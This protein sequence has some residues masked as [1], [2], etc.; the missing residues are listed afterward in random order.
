[1]SLLRTGTRPRG[2]SSEALEVIVVLKV[3]VQVVALSGITLFS[4]ML[5]FSI[6]RLDGTM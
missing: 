6:G 1:M 5:S 2:S 3:V 4:N